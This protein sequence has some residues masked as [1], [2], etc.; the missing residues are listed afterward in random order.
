M[1]SLLLGELIFLFLL[2]SIRATV[3]RKQIDIIQNLNKSELPYTLCQQSKL[4][5]HMQ[6]FVSYRI[7]LPYEFLIIEKKICKIQHNKF[8]GSYMLS[9][10]SVR[11]DTPSI[12]KWAP[13]NK[14]HKKFQRSHWPPH[15]ALYI[16]RTLQWRHFYFPGE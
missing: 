3:I 7:S 2:T 12:I 9:H 8:Y 6:R 11:S 13:V 10:D 5:F 15:S 1:F 16:W 14:W 4:H